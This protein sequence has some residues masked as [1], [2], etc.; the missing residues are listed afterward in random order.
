M[1][2]IE[3]VNGSIG[4]EIR[5]Y[6]A[7]RM[8][9][10]DAARIR[11][12][13]Y[14]HKLVVLRGQS[15]TETEYIQWARTLGRPQIY[16]QQNY[17]HPDHPEIFVS[18]NILKDGKKIGVS[19]TGK[20][21]HTDCS[22]QPEPLSFTTLSPRIFP[23]S[24][25]QTYY[26]DMEMVYQKLPA[27]LR[28]FVDSHNAVHEAKWRYKVRPE[29]VDKSITE[30]LNE[31]EKSAPPV[32]HPA[33]IVHPV[34]GNRILYIN[35]GFTTRF[36][37]MSLEDSRP[38]L[39]ELFAFIERPEHIYAHIYED[40]DLIVWDNRP[41]VHKSSG[42]PNGEKNLNYRIGVYDDLPFYVRPVE[43]ATRHETLAAV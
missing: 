37:G 23:K 27:H 8:T 43:E 11:D 32:V 14:R 41:L 15:V 35:E 42:V 13:V 12:L 6:D 34:T 20:Y 38:I 36:E 21:W 29:D 2:I 18:T 1:K 9:A 26:I 4:A 31:F 5:D 7:R 30:L 24:V 19:G 40:G 10:D 28:Q 3:P 16:F 39:Q 25:R 33:V 17:H 22:F